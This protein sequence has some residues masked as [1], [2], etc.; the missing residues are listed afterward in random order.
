MQT[1]STGMANQFRVIILLWKSMKTTKRI[2][3]HPENSSSAKGRQQRTYEH[4]P[5]QLPPG[6]GHAVE[7]ERRTIEN[8]EV[9]QQQNQ[10]KRQKY[11]P[12]RAHQSN[13]KAT[14][15]LVALEVRVRAREGSGRE[16]EELQ[17]WKGGQAPSLWWQES[18][19]RWALRRPPVNYGGIGR[20]NI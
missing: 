18:R 4:C 9:A 3:W 10:K 11:A 1:S 16:A 2:N 14:F 13:M 17:L 5:Q 6:R 12:W 20:K 8:G 7:S 19:E 15:H